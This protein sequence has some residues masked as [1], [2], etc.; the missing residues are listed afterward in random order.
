MA[1]ELYTFDEIKDE[2]IGKVGTPRRDAYEI[3]LK[4]DLIGDII[5]EARK[6]RNL[7]QAELGKL[8]G[9]QKAQVSKLENN[10]SNFSIGTIIKVFKALGA[11]VRLKIELN[12]KEIELV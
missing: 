4:L 7:T 11:E 5:K 2:I 12:K 10:T 3:E 6:K 1:L 9:V 8:I